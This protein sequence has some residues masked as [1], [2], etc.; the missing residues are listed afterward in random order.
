METAQDRMD[1]HVY[2]F[3]SSNLRNL[4]STLPSPGLSANATSSPPSQ[5]N[6]LKVSYQPSR[7]EPLLLPM[8]GSQCS[9]FFLLYLCMLFHSGENSA[10]TQRLIA[11]K[12]G[13]KSQGGD[14]FKSDGWFLS[15]LALLSLAFSPEE[16]Y[17]FLV[18]IFVLLNHSTILIHENLLT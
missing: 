10:D 7:A 15:W 16:W 2:I 4:L 18:F 6:S 9:P 3:Q 17:R 5:D 13:T 12:T 8:T 1:G 11:K 14:S